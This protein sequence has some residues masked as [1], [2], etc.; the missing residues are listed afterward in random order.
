[1]VNK[2]VNCLQ[3]SLSTEKVYDKHELTNQDLEACIS[4]SEHMAEAY[5]H[6]NEK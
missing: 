3:C 5:N 4:L 2:H 1:M 6:V